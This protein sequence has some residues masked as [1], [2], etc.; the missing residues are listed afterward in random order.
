MKCKERG[1]DGE[2]DLSQPISLQ[3]GCGGCR[4]AQLQLAYPC[5]VCG[6]LHWGD[7]SKVFNRR[8]Q[9]AFFENSSVVH[10]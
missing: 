3:T 8:K 7:G 9:R 4:G 6:R 1:C 5:K 2:I 10:R